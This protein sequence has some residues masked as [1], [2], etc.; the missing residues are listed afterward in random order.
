[1]ET[2]KDH[3]QIKLPAKKLRIN[4]EKKLVAYK[5]RSKEMG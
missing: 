3:D 5:E 2:W 4:F 1:M